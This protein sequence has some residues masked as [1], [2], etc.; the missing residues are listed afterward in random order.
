VGER[1][2]SASE[3]IVIDPAT[4]VQTGGA[5]PRTD[6]AALGWDGAAPSEP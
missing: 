3:A 4:G 1:R 6:G 2:W 5:D